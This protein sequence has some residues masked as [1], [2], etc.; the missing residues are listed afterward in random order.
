MVGEVL[1]AMT[2]LAKRGTTMVVVTHEIGFARE[3]ADSFLFLEGGRAVETGSVDILR[4]GGTH[5]RTRS[6]L[7]SVL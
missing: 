3:V 6:F 2:G 7:A 4:S 1:E 5:P